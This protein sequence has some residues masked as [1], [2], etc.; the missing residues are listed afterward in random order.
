MW[1]VIYGFVRTYAVYITFPVAVVVGV[2]GYNVEGYLRKDKQ[3]KYKKKSIREERDEREWEDMQKTDITDVQTLKSKV[4][5][6][7]TILSRNDH[8]H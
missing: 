4:D 5:I 1:P 2:V 3:Q 8:L 7:K 6:P